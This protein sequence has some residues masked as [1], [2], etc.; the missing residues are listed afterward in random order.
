[1]ILPRTGTRKRAVLG[2]L[3]DRRGS[4]VDGYE[5]ATPE[6]GGGEGLRRL[7]ELRA[8][9]WNIEERSMPNSTAWQYR[10]I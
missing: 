9:G 10:I 6:V 5:L 8:E 3:Q 2:Y 1:M 7:R 4:W